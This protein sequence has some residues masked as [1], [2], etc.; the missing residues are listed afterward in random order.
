ML[1]ILIVLVTLPIDCRLI[2]LGETG[3]W[4]LLVIEGLRHFFFRVLYCLCTFALRLCN[5]V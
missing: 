2:L 4:S 3:C 1:I 5:T